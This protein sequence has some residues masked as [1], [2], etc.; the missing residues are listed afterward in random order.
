VPTDLLPWSVVWESAAL[1]PEGFYRRATPRDHF[2][3]DVSDGHSVARRLAALV[4][5]T[6]GELNDDHFPVTITDVGA[7][8][9]RLLIQVAGLLDPAT[10]QRLEWRAIDVRPRP[11]DVPA[12][13]TWVQSD[14][15]RLPADLPPA[16]GV[17]IAHELLDDIPCDVLEIDDDGHRRLLLV[18]RASGEQQLGPSTSDVDACAHLG[19]DGRLIDGWCDQWWPRREPGARVECGR[20]RDDAW[21]ALASLVSLGTAIAVDYGHRRGE[22]D[23]GVWDG[24]TLA[25]YRHGRQVSPTVDGTANLTAHVA[26][27]SC[28][29]SMTGQ[30]PY[31]EKSTEGLW[32]LVQRMGR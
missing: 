23:D 9:A 13:I 29:A 2:G 17:L 11:L 12:W 5:Q 14:A 6:L 26:M 22:R 4:E 8:D 30:P 20:Q 27:D 25:S 28:A 31:L 15:R 1:G 7:A 32:W 24:G 16:A 10:R 19:V 3:T 21:R 18:E